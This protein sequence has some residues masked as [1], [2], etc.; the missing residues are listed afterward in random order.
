MYY[1]SDTKLVAL[2]T[3][4]SGDLTITGTF[5][6]PGDFSILTNIFKLSCR[7]LAGHM[8]ILVTTT[9]TGTDNASAKPKCSFVIP[10][11]PA[12]APT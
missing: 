5:R 3:T 7:T 2:N 6:Q 12:L 1:L 9:N 8:S 10:I 4:S 11:I